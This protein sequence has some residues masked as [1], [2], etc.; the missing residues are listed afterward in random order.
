MSLVFFKRLK[1][2]GY[3]RTDGSELSR[4]LQ[5]RTIKEY[6][7]AHD[8]HLLA[9]YYDDGPP[10]MG[11]LTALRNLEKV[12]GLVTYDLSR[13]V[14]KSDCSTESA[15]FISKHFLDSKKKIVAIA[16]NLENTSSLGEENLR[17]RLVTY[18]DVD[19]IHDA[20]VTDLRN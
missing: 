15:A 20:M 14:E 5:C 6:C 7:L 11:L 4:E 18:S 10:G 19:H 3:V 2:I 9:L 1:L 12:D 8:H 13:L 16:D 17:N